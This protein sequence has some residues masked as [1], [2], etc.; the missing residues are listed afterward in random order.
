MT[1][2]I[3][4]ISDINSILE[5]HGSGKHYPVFVDNLHTSFIQLD[6][7]YRLP[8]TSV[9]S[10]DFA[11]ARDYVSMLAEVIPQAVSGSYILQ[12]HRPKRETGKITLFKDFDFNGAKYLYVNSFHV[13]YLGGASADSIVLSPIQERT[14]AVKTERI[15][16]SSRIVPLDEIEY[17]GGVPTDFKTRQ[18]DESKVMVSTSVKNPR[19]ESISEL[20]DEVDYSDIIRSLRRY[21]K[22]LQIYGNRE[23][24]LIQLQSNTIQYVSVS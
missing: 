11:A 3:Q 1:Y 15:Y 20:F 10:V 18:Y 23:E 17:F 6:N 5:K 14:A 16:F 19:K 21:G 9:F 8:S 22:F 7:S 24:F 12:N 2:T 4:Q 13:A